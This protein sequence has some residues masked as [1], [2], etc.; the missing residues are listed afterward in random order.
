M[1]EA[2]AKCTMTRTAAR[3]EGRCVELDGRKLYSFGS[4][5]YLGLERRPELR[6]AAAAAVDE[7]GTQFSFSRAYLECALYQE[8][9]SNLEKITGRPTLVAPSTTLAHMAAL[10]VLV[11]DNDGAR[12]TDLPTPASARC[13]R[14]AP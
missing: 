2:V 8:L 4:C 1:A 7:Y 13:H 3:N 12:S 14:T 6:A 10:P 9:E 5:S 11:R